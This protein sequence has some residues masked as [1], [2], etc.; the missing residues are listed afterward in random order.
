MRRPASTLGISVSHAW[1]MAEITTLT[2][3]NAT[4]MPASS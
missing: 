4:D 3:S 1:P 2:S